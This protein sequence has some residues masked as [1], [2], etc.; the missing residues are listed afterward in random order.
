MPFPQSTFSWADAQGQGSPSN[1]PFRSTCKAH[2]IHCCTACLFTFPVLLFQWTV[3]ILICDL[4]C[5]LLCLQRISWGQDF[6]SRQRLMATEGLLPRS[7][8]LEVLNAIMFVA[9]GIKTCVPGKHYQLSY[10]HSSTSSKCEGHQH[11]GNRLWLASATACINN[12]LSH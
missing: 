3:F 5:F 11:P 9:L 6:T 8:E 10:I 4:Y 1:K 12:A 7:C 2:R